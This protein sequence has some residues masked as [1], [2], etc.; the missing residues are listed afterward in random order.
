MMVSAALTAVNAGRLAL[1]VIRVRKAHRDGKEILAV[2][3]QRA[4]GAIRDHK[5][6]REILVKLGREVPE[7][8]P[9]Q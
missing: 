2:R 6:L 3:V 9:V 4:I 7:E 8:I 1:R 5:V